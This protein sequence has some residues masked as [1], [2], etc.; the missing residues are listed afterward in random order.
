[1]PF[2]PYPDPTYKGDSAK[3]PWPGNPYRPNNTSMGFPPYMP[4]RPQG[5]FSGGIMPNAG[6]PLYTGN[7]LPGNGNPQYYLGNMRPEMGQS[8][9]SLPANEN[10]P[11]NIRPDIG[12]SNPS[13]PANG[14]RPQ[15]NVRPQQSSPGQPQNPR[16]DS[17]P[18]L[19]PEYQPHSDNTERPTG[20]SFHPN[21]KPLMGCAEMIKDHPFPITDQSPTAVHLQDLS[22]TPSST[23]HSIFTKLPIHLAQQDLEGA[24]TTHGKFDFPDHFIQ[25]L[26][27]GEWNNKL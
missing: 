15:N 12:Q 26:Y 18:Q 22:L 10:H 9:P 11:G 24:A 8:N 13:F 21:D 1:M 14:N 4:S 7:M 5:T 17:R 6:R 2:S 20:V 19:N 23:E 27:K 25:P 3:Y 16:P